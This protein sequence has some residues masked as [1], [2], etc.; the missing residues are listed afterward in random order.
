MK[1]KSAFTVVELMIV[2]IAVGILSTIVTVSF[3]AA[4]R[5]ARTA[6]NVKRAQDIINLAE[7][8]LVLGFSSQNKYPSKGPRASI[9][10]VSDSFRNA[11][12][13]AA[14][15]NLSL[16]DAPDGAHTERLLYMTCIDTDSEITGVKVA[17]WD[18]T[19][20]AVNY[21]KTGE[22]DGANITCY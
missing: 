17:Y 8:N 21:T 7:Q 19:T 18:Y 2:L 3:S 13:E 11:L 9:Y 12:P 5:R 6:E 15:A 20:N 1:T 4:N 22:T 10:N 14:R 16:T